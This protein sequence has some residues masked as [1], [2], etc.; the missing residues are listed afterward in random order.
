M[1]SSLF[2]I[3]KR[4]TKSLFDPLITVSWF[5]IQEV[6]VTSP[7]LKP[8]FLLLFVTITCKCRS[9]FAKMNEYFPR[10]HLQV[11]SFRSQACSSF[12]LYQVDLA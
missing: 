2:L 8:F 6:L 5:K 1:T 9:S 10:S 7:S 11:E 3:S 12:H 4:K